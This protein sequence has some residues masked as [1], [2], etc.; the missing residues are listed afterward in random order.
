MTLAY[1][2]SAR[3]RDK[4]WKIF[5]TEMRP[6]PESTIL[7]AGFSDKEYSATD[8]YLEK[9]YPFPQ[10]ITALG[11]DEP[12]DFLKHY[13][14]IEAIQYDGH[15]FPFSINSFDIVWSNAVLEHVGSREKQVLFLKEISRVGHRAFITTPNKCFPI[16]LHTRIPFLHWLPK[17]WFDKILRSLGKSWATGDYMN[18]LTLKNLKQLLKDANITHYKIIKNRFLG[19]TM[20]FIVIIN[21]NQ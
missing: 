20:N 2:I 8:N 13:P 9:N 6:L 14:K 17:S 5:L 3:N 15:H 12:T 10:K 7:D 16:E 19:F 18:L 1:T 11:I 21:S 4:K